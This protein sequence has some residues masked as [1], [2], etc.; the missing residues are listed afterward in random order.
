MNKETGAYD[1][2][3]TGPSLQPID[4]QYFPARSL[5]G[6][7]QSDAAPTGPQD[8]PH[9][10]VRNQ[11]SHGS[12]LASHFQSQKLQHDQDPYAAQSQS[13]TQPFTPQEQYG[14]YEEVMPYRAEGFKSYSHAA[15]PTQRPDTRTNCP[16]GFQQFHG[17]S[18]GMLFELCCSLY[19]TMST[20]QL[21]KVTLKE[22]RWN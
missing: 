18:L 6:Y 20:H 21:T 7:S 1:R 5:S 12:L 9:G 10:N 4:L 2:G 17:V 3:Y 11:E 13:D 15:T 14:P 22:A 16:T 8:I 19:Q